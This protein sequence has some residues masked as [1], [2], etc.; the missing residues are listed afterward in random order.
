M[1][2]DTTAVLAEQI[3]SV[4]HAI[5]SG[6]AVCLLGAGFSAGATDA[7]GQAIPSS[8]QLTDELKALFSI[9]QSEAVSL[10]EVAEF[11][12]DS[13]DLRLKL[14]SY[15]V[16]RLTSCR[17]GDHHRSFLAKNW[18]AIFTTNFDDLAE[19]SYPTANRVCVTPATA[20]GTIPPTLTPI[21]YMHGRALDLREGDVD[22]G[23]VIS[24]SNYLKL[25][26]RNRDLYSR[27]FN[28][29]FCARAIV[30]VGYSLRDLEIASGLLSAGGDVRSKTIIVTSQ[31]DT[32]F[33]RARLAKFGTVIPCGLEGF[34]DLYSRATVSTD[35]SPDFQFLIEQ[36][37]APEEDENEAEDFL[38][39]ILRGEL[40]PSRYL[41]QRVA[42]NEPYCVER[43]A[44]K[45]VASA[46]V[47]RFVVSSDFGNGKSAFLGQV[48]T[49]LL[50][51]GYRV[52]LVE[53]RLPEVFE[54][55]EAALRLP[56]PVAFLVDDL[57]RY[58]EVVQF[59]GERLHGQAKLIC[60]T[61]GD[62]DSRLE[63]IALKLGGAYRSIDLNILDEAEID[64]WDRLLERWGYWEE[65]AG[66]QSDDRRRFL[67]E[68]C[69]REN[70]SIVLSLFEDSRVAQAIDRIVSFFLKSTSSHREAFAG[71]L[72]A[73]LC[74]KHVSWE[75]VV[76]WLHLDESKLRQDIAKSEIAFLFSR[77]RNWNLFTS[78]QL[79]DFILR[80]KFV[81]EDRDILLGV[82][83]DIVL[84]TAS[85][86]NDE[87]SGW[88]FQENLK[89]LMKYRFLTRLFGDSDASQALIG[90]V[91]RRLSDA[92]R[93]R[94]NPQF[95]LQYAM[96]RMAVDD[97]PGAET[98]IKT[99]LGKAAERGASYS[100]FQILDQRARL[101]LMKNA[102][103][104]DSYS[105]S[106]L[107]TTIKDLTDL[108]SSK[109]YDVVYTMRS[110]PLIL[111]FLEVHIDRLSGDCRQRLGALLDLLHQKAK[112]FEHFPRSQKGETKVLKKALSDARLVFFNG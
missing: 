14:V 54:D 31:S 78:A 65:R 10:S 94:N 44:V 95:W 6:A 24:E 28:E 82:Y 12:E 112:E 90:R 56:V 40:D 52:F 79:A 66:L 61:R 64:Q 29:I 104:P 13:P 47:E 70:R 80:R 99:A 101:F 8:S 92:P 20:S 100:P 37:V 85:S 74:Q 2:E 16:T 25:E 7:T 48:S 34:L 5:D 67:V 108:A 109:D 57:L 36:S 84:A 30:V 87:R 89:E 17:P 111:S 22:P 62:Q 32:N 19:Q 69:G 88:D 15:L 9:P 38:S 50:E 59:I 42:P 41:R 68:A 107:R 98:Y 26:Q 58:R 18:R 55:I 75:S 33:T 21:Y 63:Q 46:P 97:L 73:S 45:E 27:F 4:R 72:V 81:A 77:G 96:S 51:R 110:M 3:E 103:Q 35:A 60:T 11:A 43:S 86:A 105:E 102:R 23:L 83:T 76:A 91:Y 1:G 106:E 39:L 71:L 93:I 53:T 49:A